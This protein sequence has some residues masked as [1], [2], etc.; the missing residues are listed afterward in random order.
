[1]IRL[2]HA[3]KRPRCTCLR[4]ARDAGRSSLNASALQA[5][6]A[7]VVPQTRQQKCATDT[8]VCLQVQLQACGFKSV[9]CIVHA[10][11]PDTLPSDADM[12]L[13]QHEPSCIW[14][15]EGGLPLRESS[16]CQSVLRNGESAARRSN[17]GPCRGHLPAF[18]L[19]PHQPRWL[20]AAIDDRS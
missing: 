18:A 16:H 8:F 1:M 14:A 2:A 13:P 12:Q 17:T 19:P 11:T 20:C 3:S 4:P 9:G 6:Q 5:G 10:A 7:E 15:V